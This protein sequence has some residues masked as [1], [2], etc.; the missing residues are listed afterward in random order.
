MTSTA[1]PRLQERTEE[2][3]ELIKFRSFESN[4]FQLE[5]SKI[6]DELIVKV[7]KRLIVTHPETST[8]YLYEMLS[9]FACKIHP[10]SDP[11][12]PHYGEHLL[13]ISA[14]VYEY[15]LTSEVPIALDM[16]S[17]V[18]PIFQNPHSFTVAADT[19]LANIYSDSSAKQQFEELT[20]MSKGFPFELQEEALCKLLIEMN[21]RAED[22]FDLA[23]SN[24]RKTISALDRFY[25]ATYDD[26]LI[27]LFH[28]LRL[29]KVE[30]EALFPQIEEKT[31]TP[32]LAQYIRDVLLFGETKPSTTHLD[33]ESWSDEK[34]SIRLLPHEIGTLPNIEAIK[35]DGHPLRSLPHT[36]KNLERL[37]HFMCANCELVT[38]PEGFIELEGL[39]TLHMYGNKLQELP[40]DFGRMGSLTQID[41]GLNRLVTIPHSIGALSRLRVLCLSRNPIETI[42]EEL[43]SCRALQSLQLI[44]TRV[45]DIPVELS[46]RPLVISVS[47]AKERA[48]GA[49]GGGE[50]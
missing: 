37:K 41:L 40:E 19:L 9:A 32:D 48:G 30:R 3:A 46:R 25:K 42:P 22:A 4:P 34:P 50:G 33:L 21:G 17:R 29:P 14:K 45:V 13:Q 24:P 18:D 10:S 6:P 47:L 23:M 1:I 8:P 28:A 38:L 20:G 43:A 31:S 36:I 27:H 44:N 11:V 35:I 39:E 49:A 15:V 5:C 26:A 16:H 12:P 7:A 2:L